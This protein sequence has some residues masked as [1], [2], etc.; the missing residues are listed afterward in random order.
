MIKSIALASLLGEA[1]QEPV[2][3]EVCHQLPDHH[4]SIPYPTPYQ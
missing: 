1:A 4:R 3:V 2:L